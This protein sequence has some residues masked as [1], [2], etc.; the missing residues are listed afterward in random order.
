MQSV[1]VQCVLP[2]ASRLNNDYYWYRCTGLPYFLVSNAGACDRSWT[3]C[4]DQMKRLWKAECTRQALASREV[5]AANNAST[6]RL[7]KGIFRLLDP[8]QAAIDDLA[9][10]TVVMAEV[11]LRGRPAPWPGLLI[12]TSWSRQP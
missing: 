8:V 12:S 9:K 10:E 4:A 2:R 5:E 6:L 1:H 11:S 7:Q 3:W